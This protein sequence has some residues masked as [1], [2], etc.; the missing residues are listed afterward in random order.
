M[1][2]KVSASSST[3]IGGFMF[4]TAENFLSSLGNKKSQEPV[5]LTQYKSGVKVYHKRFGEG[6]I[7]YV[8]AEGD[9]LK[10]DINF[11]KAGHKR[12]MAKYANLEV[13]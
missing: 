2:E 8:E 4:K 6:T 1:Q 7:N 3:N 11:E 12:L 9:D 5:D 13:I 10:V